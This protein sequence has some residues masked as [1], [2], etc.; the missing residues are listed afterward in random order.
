M[1]D[2]SHGASFPNKGRQSGLAEGAGGQ[3]QGCPEPCLPLRALFSPEATGAQAGGGR[4]GPQ[5][6]RSWGPGRLGR[7]CSFCCPSPK[8][9]LPW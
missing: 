5:F 6:P 4:R 3:G 8:P 9:S 1:A 7:H 2:F